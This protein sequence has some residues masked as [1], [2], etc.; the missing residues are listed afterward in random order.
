MNRREFVSGCLSATTSAAL[1]GATLS[2]ESEVQRPSE[3]PARPGAPN[4][5]IFMPDQQNGATVLS[6]S[7]VMYSV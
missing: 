5:L 6:E 4:V 7:A 3:Q 2:S 1:A